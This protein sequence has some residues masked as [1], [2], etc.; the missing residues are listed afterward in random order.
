MINV[1]LSYVQDCRPCDPECVGCGGPS[2]F[3]CNECANYKQEHRCVASCS[4]DYFVDDEMAKTCAA[5][6]RQCLQCHGP[7]AA[8]CTSCRILKL[9]HNLDER[10]P[11]SPVCILL[12]IFGYIVERTN[13]KILWSHFLQFPS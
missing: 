7:T 2:P 12:Y 5:C 8:D 1:N 6:D 3:L 4:S 9:Y 11:D 13:T 10:N